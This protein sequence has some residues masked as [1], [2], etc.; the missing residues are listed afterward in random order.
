MN[1]S[2]LP[3]SPARHPGITTIDYNPEAN[4][5]T[6]DSFNSNPEVN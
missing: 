6:L 1:H 4:R 3:L 2:I 5:L